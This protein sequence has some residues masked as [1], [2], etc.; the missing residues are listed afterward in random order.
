M[1]IFADAS[2]AERGTVH[3]NLGTDLDSLQVH[4]CKWSEPVTAV[5]PHISLSPCVTTHNPMSQSLHVLSMF[6][7]THL[8]ICN[9]V[10]DEM[11]ATEES[12]VMVCFSQSCLARMTSH[13]VMSSFRPS[14][15]SVSTE[16]YCNG[17]PLICCNRDRHCQQ[18]P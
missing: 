16:L 6:L 3:D 13:A 9:D 4:D 15:G 12:P 8:R 18:C 1:M 14:D 2:T 11:S 17:A 5:P 10:Q 7:G